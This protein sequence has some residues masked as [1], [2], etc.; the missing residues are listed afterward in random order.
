MAGFTKH[1][2]AKDLTQTKNSFNTYVKKISPILPI[3][4]DL[5]CIIKKLKKYYPYEWRLL[6]EKYK[7]YTRADRKLIR[8]GKKARYKTVTPEK[9]ISI[10]PQTKAILSK[11]Y[12]ANYLNSFS[13]VQR[14]QNEEKIKKER[15]PKIQRI[16]DRIA[17]AKSRVQQM[18]PIYFEKM[19]GL[20]DRKGTTQKDRVYIMYELTKYYS[21]EIVQFFS[22]K[23]HSE[24]NFQL[25][26]MAFSYLQQFY[27]YTELRSQKHME[28]RTT[29]KKKRKEMREYAKQKFNIKEI[30]EEL[31]FRINNS[32]EQRLKSFDYFLSHSSKDHAAVQK[33]IYYLNQNKKNVY[34]D[35][36]NDDD[37]L[38][39]NLVGDATK[40]IIE[41]RIKQSKNVILIKSQNSEK[42][43]WVKYELSY[44]K[45]LHKRI[46]FINAD[47]LL[48][49][50]Y[51]YLPFKDKAYFMS[52]YSSLKLY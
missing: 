14:T 46:Y 5:N 22:R 21:P 19:M 42:S 24:Y 16:D 33:L 20:Y 1:K 13:E 10:L 50:K 8:V 39:R 36:F 2:Y 48:K 30:P 6:E 29:N 38:K 41:T 26:L 18:E 9:L 28:L 11:D 23:A 15:L 47:D 40:S 25:R 3:E 52:N 51:L 12:K 27:H 45:A 31:E 32:P 37:Y 35:W 17:K 43:L 7:E 34:C 44:A 4:F 49:G